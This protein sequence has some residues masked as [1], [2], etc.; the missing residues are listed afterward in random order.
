[1]TTAAAIG[2]RAHSGWAAAV[3]ITGSP[4]APVAAMR[5]R[6]EMGLA[7]PYHAAVSLEIG[8]AH[9][10]IAECAARAAS[11]A[12]AG[13]RGMI[14]DL[15]P[16]GLHVT[17]CGLLLASGRPLPALE[18]ILRSHALIHTAEGEHFRDALRAAVGACGLRLTTVKEHDL[19]IDPL[20]AAMGK[21][22]G[23]P[24]GQDQ[25]LSS[26]VGWLALRGC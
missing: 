1:M 7:Q 17:G 9:Q 16:L 25:K 24:W 12:A 22:M 11:M 21:S 14:E 3:A 23:P 18:G 20:C 2:F 6:I 5:R 10:L 19:E 8:E 13:L 26:M 15:R 4:D